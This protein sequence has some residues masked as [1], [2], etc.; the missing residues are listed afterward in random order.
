[1]I[2]PFNYGEGLL[3]ECQNGLGLLVGLRQHGG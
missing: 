1:M 2:F 3:Q